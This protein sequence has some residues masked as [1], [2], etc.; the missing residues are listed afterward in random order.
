MKKLIATAAIIIS[1]TLC[2]GTVL[3]PWF[4]ERSIE[5]QGRAD[6][7]LEAYDTVQSSDGNFHYHARDS[8]LDLSLL[9][10]LEGFGAEIEAVISN[11]HHHSL[12]ADCFRLTGRYLALNDSV[13]DP[14]SL[15]AGLTLT[16][17]TT[18]GLD[19][20]SSFHHGHCEIEATLAI[21]KETICYDRWTSRYWAVAGFGC[22]TDEGSPWLR[23]DLHYEN[24]FDS[25]LTLHLFVNTLW[26]LGHNAITPHFHGY[27][28]ISH[29]SVDIG[30]KISYYT[31]CDL[32]LSLG[33]SY[34]PYSHNFPKN[35]NIFM[36]DLLYPFSL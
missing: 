4:P 22:A 19:D 30:T 29:H 24:N 10:S 28:S 9:T 20:I 2:W 11:T 6:Y 18:H 5:I 36:L 27:G 25:F 23:A 3:Q 14:V 17:P 31:E 8:F 13:G 12:Y 15:M 21:G 26:G 16:L 34:R 32:T 1:P 33:Y 35:T 7:T